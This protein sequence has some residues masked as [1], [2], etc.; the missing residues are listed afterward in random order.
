MRHVR[1]ERRK[2]AIFFCGSFL[3]SGESGRGME[4]EHL[5]CGARARTILLVG[6]GN[7][8]NIQQIGIS[9]GV[10]RC[11][12][13]EEASISAKRVDVEVRA[14]ARGE[15]GCQG[16]RVA[17]LR[18][19]LHSGWTSCKRARHYCRRSPSRARRGAVHEVC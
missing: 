12:R 11:A 6:G 4:D 8:Q 16:E 5:R 3:Q 2:Y 15:Y 19:L 14:R 9:N 17:S 1:G 10:R 13:T 18:L 7:T